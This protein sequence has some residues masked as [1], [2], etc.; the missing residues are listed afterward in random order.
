MPL[1]VLCGLHDGGGNIT[2]ELKTAATLAMMGAYGA[3]YDKFT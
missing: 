3:M 1:S 2:S